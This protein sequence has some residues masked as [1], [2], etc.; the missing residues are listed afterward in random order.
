MTVE[1]EFKH[2]HKQVT[3]RTIANTP[4]AWQRDTVWV[5]FAVAAASWAL[6]IDD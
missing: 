2:Q 5:I 3:A 6:D 4:A 1:C